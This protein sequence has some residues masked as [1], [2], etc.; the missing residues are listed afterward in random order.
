MT[1]RK[2]SLLLTIVM[3][4]FNLHGSS[5]FFQPDS[6]PPLPPGQAVILTGPSQAC[7]G[8]TCIYEADVPVACV[9]QWAI[10][11]VIQPDTVSP[12]V[13]VYTSAGLQTVTLAFI[14]NGQTSDPDTVFTEVSGTPSQPAPISGPVTVCEYT[15]HTY[16]TVVG[17]FDTCQWSVNGV[18]QPATGPEMTYSFGG[19]GQYSIEVISFNPCGISPP[20]TLIV[21]ASGT[22][23]PPPSPIQGPGES[24]ETYQ[25]TYTTTVGPGETCAWWVDGVQ[26]GTTLPELTLTWIERGDHLIEARAVGV[27]GT[28]NPVFKNVSV[29]YFPEVFLGNDTIILQGQTLLLDAGN[30]GSEYLWSTGSTT[31]TIMVSVAGI[32]WVNITNICGT[33]YDEIEVSVIVGVNHHNLAEYFRIV[34]YN[35]KLYIID[36]PENIRSIAVYDMAGSCIFFEKEVVS[37]M[38]PRGG[39]YIVKIVTDQRAYSGKVYIH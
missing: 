2:I 9:C 18:I 15:T 16:T 37:L 32:Y 7:T 35:G 10:N 34:S 29:L 12:L 39:L 25:E 23:P 30:P 33:G 27:C 5:I 38:I 1:L 28:G 21:T 4:C 31:Q 22:A 24:C 19:A 6:I 14:C 26:Q 17:S 20:Q 3:L 13:Q 8:D 36:P 11:G